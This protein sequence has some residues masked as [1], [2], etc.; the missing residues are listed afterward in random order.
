MSKLAVKLASCP[1]TVAFSLGV[2]VAD[3]ICSVN[4]DA[5]SALATPLISSPSCICLCTG[6]V[7]WLATP[8]A[9]SNCPTELAACCCACICACEGT[10]PWAA[11]VWDRACSTWPAACCDCI[12]LAS[13]TCWGVA[14]AVPATVVGTA[15]SPATWPIPLATNVSCVA[16]GLTVCICAPAGNPGWVIIWA[17]MSP[18][19]GATSSVRILPSGSVI[20]WP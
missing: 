3:W 8:W 6:L 12:K 14:V 13:V 18:M 2:A 16:T 7:I 11:W 9:A 4:L 10:W 5:V 20:G 17:L 15:K 1:C 19:L